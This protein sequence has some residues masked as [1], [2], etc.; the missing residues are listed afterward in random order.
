MVLIVSIVV[1]VLLALWIISLYNSLVKLRNNRENAFAD[2]DVQLK[3]RHD[4][5]PQ[6]VS[7]VKGYAAH[8]KDTLERVIN[9]RNGAMGAR[10][11]DEKIKA[12]N[13]LSSALAGLK[14]TLEAYPDL[15]A[16]QN[17][18]QL[19][20]EIADLENKLSAVRRYFNSATKEL[21]N[22]VETFPSN[23]IA[24]MF[25]FHKEIMFDLGTQRATL[26][27]APKIEF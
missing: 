8:E 2:I 14:I 7:T 20:E 10:T 22:A 18:L 25:G 9:A 5:I 17:F 27:E 1:L 13:A 12:E 4:L 6:L 24:G 3:Q 15:K 21:N 16:N 11:I 26:E 19:Q 23:L